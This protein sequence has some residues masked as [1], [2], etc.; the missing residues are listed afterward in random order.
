MKLTPWIPALVC[1]FVFFSACSGEKGDPTGGDDTTSI[2]ISTPVASDIT[3]EKATLK[4]T[5]T[6]NT[7]GAILKKGV[8]YSTQ[9]TPSIADK[10][11]EM[12]SVGLSMNLT[13]SDLKAETTYYVRAFA[14]QSNANPVYSKEISFTTSASSTTPELDNYK[15]P[16][17]ADNYT[18]IAGW[19]KHT[20]WNLA[21]VHDPTVMKADDGYYYMYQ[22]D[23][24]YGNEHEKSNGHFLARRSKNL[25]DWEY[26]GPTMSTA[27]A[28]VKTKLNEMRTAQGL[29]TIDNPSY[30]YW[31]PVARKVSAGKY[32]M[33]Y[34]IVVNNYIKTGKESTEANFDNSWTERAFIGLME[35][36][37]PA[38]NVWEDKGYVVCSSTDLEKNWQRASLDNWDGYFKWNA[39]DPTYI[40]DQSGDHWLIYGSWHSGL[41]AL[42][43]NA[44]TGKPLNELGNPWETPALPNYGKLIH[45]RNNNRW[46]A[47]EGPEVIY[48]PA[49][50]FYYLFVAYDWVDVSYNTRVARSTKVDGPYLS[51]DGT[52]ITKYSK[53]I[54]PIVTHPYK[55]NNSIGWVGISHCAVFDD[56]EGNW[57]YASQGRMPKNVEGI[58]ASNAIMMGH[59][60]SIRWTTNGWPVVMPERYGAV[61]K[62]A[63]TEAELV[64]RWEHIELTSVWE[65]QHTSTSMTLSADHK[66]TAG[67]WKD[68]TWSYNADKQ[69][70]TANGVEL[71]LQRETDWEA[72]PRTH[73]IVY[74]GY[75]G[76]KTYWGKKSK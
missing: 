50:G 69:I 47:S 68:G 33:Y 52:D 58:N 53:D 55:F 66:I 56:G 6:T 29:P 75:N 4:A 71:C 19:N 15:A 17:Y 21:N 24:S 64:G 59:V 22:T 37:D 51:I 38:G 74:G 57:Y 12:N 3:A 27:P 34:S 43:L 18:D 32:R 14:T 7:P 62:V 67:T 46:Q 1:C 42:Q 10:T 44:T 20:Q 36:S 13:L 45:N 30:G 11:V 9:T 54:Y 70:L 73:T 63:I 65:K 60:R 2:T 48:N 28:W 35:T 39:I 72:N 5:I 40:I 61:P 49:T 26:V 16:T 76:T 25:V 23:A 31:A 41:T 8:C